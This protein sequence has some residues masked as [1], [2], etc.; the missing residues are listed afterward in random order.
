MTEAAVKLKNTENPNCLHLTEQ[1]DLEL[2]GLMSPVEQHKD[3]YV[4]DYVTFSIDSKNK[5]IY[6]NKPCYA[7]LRP[8]YSTFDIFCMSNKKL[9]QT[10]ELTLEQASLFLSHLVESGLV[11]D[12]ILLWEDTDGI[13]LHIPRKKFNNHLIYSMLCCYRW[14]DSSPE[15]VLHFLKIMEDPIY[16]HPL[17]VL[18]AMMTLYV[19]NNN[20]NMCILNS[21]DNNHYQAYEFNIGNRW[22]NPLY[23]LAFYLL[24]KKGFFKDEGKKPG[25]VTACIEKILKEITPPAENKAY[26][27]YYIEKK[28]HI[29]YTGFNALYDLEEYNKDT[30]DEA[31]ADIFKIER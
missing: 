30:V 19:K 10:Q 11:S 17:Q 26:L 16:R 3:L 15:L 29:L 1:E 12:E 28:E 23:G 8:N 14:I 24:F 18:T 9:N 20:H 2:K 25:H 6:R 31:L 5:T 21:Y 13:R 27:K 22:A 7:V 4:S